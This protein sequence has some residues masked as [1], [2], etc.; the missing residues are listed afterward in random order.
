MKN[1]TKEETKNSFLPEEDSAGVMSEERE[2]LRVRA[3]CET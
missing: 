2:E 3:G 1:H